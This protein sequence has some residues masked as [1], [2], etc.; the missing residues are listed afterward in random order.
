[1]ERRSSYVG[2]LEREPTQLID[3]YWMHVACCDYLVGDAKNN[4]VKNRST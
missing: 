1:M 3:S 2:P 4:S